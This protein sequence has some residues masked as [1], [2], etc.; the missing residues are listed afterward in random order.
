MPD[1]ILT[2]LTSEGCGH[3]HTLRGDGEL[4]NGK[5]FTNYS[6]IKTHLDPLENGNTLK[7]LNIHFLSMSGKH[8]QIGEISKIYLKGENI[9]QEK[10]YSSRKGEVMVK[11]C[12]LD[13]RNKKTNIGEKSASVKLNWQEFLNKKIPKNIE[14]YTYFFPCFIVFGIDDW[15][16][17]GN[18]LGITNA[19]F[20]QRDK[21]GIFRIEKSGNSLSERNILP[22]KLVTEAISGILK[23]EP[24]KDLF[25]KK[26]EPK[27]GE[28]K[29]EEPKKEEPKSKCKFIILPYDDE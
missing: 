24:H 26:G 14:N 3:C 17:G 1:I 11:I 18:I 16:K 22:Q 27:K 28:P 19:G 2:L 29:K 9:F 15:K 23:L 10:Y 25:K 20:T 5:Q 4:G 12:S 8:N 13:K 6:F 7:I 21:E